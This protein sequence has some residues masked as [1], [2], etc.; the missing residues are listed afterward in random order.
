MPKIS[1]IIPVKNEEKNIEK[2]VTKVHSSI[3]DSKISY[4]ILFIDDH[5]TDKTT[6]VA[7]KLQKDYPIRLFTK[8]G[9][10]GKGYSIIEGVSHAQSDLIC[11][12]DADLQ[13]D[14]KHIPE[15]LSRIENSPEVGVVIAERRKYRGRARRRLASRLNAFILGKLLFNLP[16]DIQSGLKIFRKEIALH[17]DP[18]FVGPWSFDI[19]LL[20]TAKETGFTIAAVPIT[21]EH[22][23]NGESKIKMSSVAVELVTKA[24]SLKLK[25]KKTFRIQPDKE[26]NMIGAGFIHKKSKFVTHTTLHHDHSAIHTLHS[27]QRIFIFGLIGLFL[28]ST[29]VNLVN[30]LIAI[31][32]VLSTVYLLDVLFN[33]FMVLKSLHYQYEISINDKE[34]QELQHSQLPIYSILCPLYK[35]AHMIPQFVQGISQIDW[36]LDKLDVMLLLEE[37]DV[38]TI[39]AAKK[40]NLPSFVRIVVV[41]DSQPKTKPKA[42]NYGLAYAKGEYVVIFDAEDIPDPLQLKKAYIAFQ[43]VDKDVVCLQAK[44]NY[45]NP[46]QNF[47]T[48]LFTAEYSL[49]FD[50]ILPGLQAL[51][52]TIPLGGTSNHFRKNELIKIEGWD[53]FNVTED[54]DLGTRLFKKGYKTAIIDS[55]TLEEANSNVMNWIRQRSRW[56]KGYIQTYFVHMREPISFTKNHGIHALLFNVIIG[57]KIAFLFI[58][59]ILWLTTIAYFTLYAYVGP[60][61]EALF[62]SVIFYMAITS[63]VFGN[64]LYLYYYMIGSAK[65]GHWTLIKYIYFVPF[66]WLLVSV[67]SLWALY[68]LIF[69][70]H[71]W[72][73]TIHGFHLDPSLRSA[74]T[75]TNVAQQTIEATKSAEQKIE[76]KNTIS[77]SLLIVGALVGYGINFVTNLYLGKNLTNEEFSLISLMGSFFFLAAILLGPLSNTITH[78]SAYI[79]G[80]Y[81]TVALSLWKRMRKI[82][83]IGSILLAVTWTLSISYLGIFFKSESLLPFILF[84]P[85]WVIGTIVAL[86]RGFILGNHLY[87]LVAFVVIIEAIAKL[88]ISIA[89]VSLGYSHYVY[90]AMPLSLTL[91]LGILLIANHAFIKKITNPDIKNARFPK[92]FFLTSLITGT[93]TLAFLSIDLILAKH[94][95]SVE[96]AGKYALLAFI[97]KVIFFIG[98]VFSQFINPMISKKSGENIDTLKT[99]YKIYIGILAASLLGYVSLGLLSSITL[100]VLFGS[101]AAGIIPYTAEYGLALLLLTLGSAFVSYHQARKEYLHSAVSLFIVPAQI[102]G[103]Y[104]FHQDLTMFVHVM[105]AICAV[106]FVT[107]FIMHIFYNFFYAL[108]NNIRDFID[109][110]RSQKT[111]EQAKTN[112]RILIFNWR[113]T[114]HIWAGGAEVYLHN[115]AKEWVKLGHKVTIFCGNDGKNPRNQ[116]I[117][118]I[119][120]IRR[121]GFYTVYMWGMLYYL[122]RLRNNF[123]IVI[124]SQNGV[125]F[126]TP[127]YVKVPKVLLIHHVHQ[128]VFNDHLSYPLATLAKFIEAKLMPLAYKNTTHVTVSSSSR[129]EMLKLGMGKSSDIQIINPGIYTKQFTKSVKTAHPTFIYLGRLKAYKNID[130]IIKA[131]AKIV[132]KH[133][134]AKLFIAG[135]GEYDT[136]LLKLVNDKNIG[137]QVIFTQRV[138]EEEKNLL[139]G[140]SWAALQ[141]SMIEGFGITVIEANATGTPVIASRVNGLMDS[142]VEGKTGLLCTPKSVDEFYQRMLEICEN[143]ILRE[144]LSQNAYVWS[145]RFSW[146]KSGLKFLDTIENTL[147]QDVDRKERY[148]SIRVSK[149]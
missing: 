16:H 104:Y 136:S 62:P 14:P 125:P 109:L 97:G 134:D 18:R 126:F 149:I 30:T 26:D 121:G 81:N 31:M 24:L 83:L 113:D 143:Q 88:L 33:L 39:A 44:L 60:Q 90:A 99:F 17:I 82:G 53:P 69:K 23:E 21:F 96:D 119:Q 50:V 3:S 59:P 7:K 85:V 40:M 12:I 114:R 135:T 29:Y 67:A 108:V 65:R 45:Y 19:P 37:D 4:E 77:S 111:V 48:R 141:P 46:D 147:R 32:A 25:H 9:K 35:E 92:K 110:F 106:Y 56:I 139:L 27:W 54:C 122:L 95:L 73:K 132:K 51:G 41:P 63:L 49:W 5:S 36:P 138:S 58:N 117:D 13:Y 55:I 84:A 144:E 79:K 91:T 146:K 142:V 127:L 68:Q 137:S 94:F 93:A 131:F 71:Y 86:D 103:V 34:I 22:R 8:Q 105:F 10:A 115:N 11:M 52:T 75:K 15:M 72:E 120:I 47:L 70:P 112:Y 102:L 28:I 66:Y 128:E 1:I 116:V 89:F 74:P 124:D 43:Q 57:G 140:K 101:K 87:G 61:I 42:T 20:F 98:T 80:K 2:L 38:A 6:D 133:P 130:V 107:A 76:K 145:K 118:G 100:P 78:Q 129:K 148:L 64:F 123:D